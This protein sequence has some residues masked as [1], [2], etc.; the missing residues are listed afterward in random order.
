M[1]ST[2]RYRGVEEERDF[3]EVDAEEEEEAEARRICCCWAFVE[4]E[5]DRGDDV[6]GEGADA[7][8]DERLLP[9]ILILIV[10]LLRRFRIRC[11]NSSR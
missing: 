3:C 4:G 8:F 1:S 9:L 10:T 11:F 5:T 2:L 6:A 7:E